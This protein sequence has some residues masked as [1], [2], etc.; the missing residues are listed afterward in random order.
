MWEECSQKSSV[1]SGND[2]NYLRR[3]RTGEAVSNNPWFGF[4]LVTLG[5]AGVIGFAA[6]KIP[7]GSELFGLITLGLALINA[8]AHNTTVKEVQTLRR[9]VAPSTTPYTKPQEDIS[10]QPLIPNEIGETLI[11]S[12][13]K[14]I[15]GPTAQ[16]PDKVIGKR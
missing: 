4:A 1:G 10:T 12:D 15:G 3:K 9:M 6:F 16:D 2:D 11:L 14:V 7:L 13:P 8:A 5:V